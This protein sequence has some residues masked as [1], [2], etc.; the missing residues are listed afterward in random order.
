[1]KLAIVIP[2]FGRDL[3]GGAEQQ[4]WQI[5][6]RLAARGHNVNVLTTCCRSHQ[7]DWA[8]NHLPAG[9]TAEPEGFRVRRFPVT[10][11]DRASFD[12]VCAPLMNMEREKLTPGASPIP[13]DEASIFVNELIKSP[14]LLEFLSAQRTRFDWFLFLPYL[15]GPVLHGI[16]IVGERAILQPCLHDEAYAYLPQVADAFHLAARLLFNSDGEMELALRLFGP[17]IWRKSTVV[18]EGVEIEDDALAALSNNGA[19]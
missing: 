7:D 6:A 16:S 15:Y 9:E 1:M 14:E 3:K 5:A 10:P 18:G 13:A 4:A 12:R 2:W 8:T 11:R 17:G 19:D